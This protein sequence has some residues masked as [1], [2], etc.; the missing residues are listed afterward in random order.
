MEKL[1][2]HPQLMIYELVPARVK[3]AS[4]MLMH[5]FFSC[6]CSVRVLVVLWSH[7]HIVPKFPGLNSATPVISRAMPH[8][9]HWQQQWV[10]ITRLLLGVLAPTRRG[11]MS[12][13]RRAVTCGA[14]TLLHILSVY[15]TPRAAEDQGS[16]EFA[17]EQYMMVRL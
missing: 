13:Y 6:V 11:G 2:H 5:S 1:M 16:E 8:S 3:A 10:R 15:G 4:C 14:N 17:D 9:A 7:D 12:R